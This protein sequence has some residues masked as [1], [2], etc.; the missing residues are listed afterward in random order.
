MG[1]KIYYKQNIDNVSTTQS[2]DTF[3]NIFTLNPLNSP[4]GSAGCYAGATPANGSQMGTYS[5]ATWSGYDEESSFSDMRDASVRP[6]S[7]DS[8]QNLRFMIRFQGDL[9]YSVGRQS[10]K[11]T[12]IRPERAELIAS[13]IETN[14]NR[15]SY[16][17]DSPYTRSEQPIAL[18]GSVNSPLLNA[19]LTSLKIN[20][21][22]F[23]PRFI[24][25]E[26]EYYNYNAQMGGYQNLSTGTAYTK[27]WSEIK[28]QDKTA[29]GAD[30]DSDLFDNG[31]KEIQAVNP[32]GRR[33]VH[34]I[35]VALQPYY[36]KSSYRLVNDAYVQSTNPDDGKVY[37]NREQ[38]GS[39]L[40][41]QNESPSIV[42][43]YYRAPYLYVMT[44]NYDNNSGGV[45]YSTP[46]GIYFTHHTTGGGV[47]YFNGYTIS[48]NYQKLGGGSSSWNPA[49]YA[50]NQNTNNVYKDS[51]SGEPTSTDLSIYSSISENDIVISPI[52]N[53]TDPYTGTIFYLQN[54]GQAYSFDLNSR[55]VSPITTHIYPIQ[56]LWATVA[57]LGCYVAADAE[58]ATKA[59][60]GAYTGENNSLYLGYMDGSGIT[61]GTMLQ[62]SDIVDS[63]QAGIDDIIG[64]TPYTP[65]E[66]G[67]GGGG[68]GS[69]PSN[70][71][72]P[73]GKG[74]GKLTGAGT[75]GHKTREFGSGSVTYYGL[76]VSQVED[77]KAALWSQPADFYDAIQIA[78]RQNTSI[79]DYIASFR[80]YPSNMNVMGISIGMA[81]PVYLGTGAKFSKAD[82]TD[83]LLN[84][85]TGFFG[86]IEWCRWNLSDFTGWRENFLDYAPYLKMSIYLPYAGTF[87][88]DPQVVASMNP[89]QQAT[90]YA[91][92]CVDLN[93]G[94]LTYFI[95]A[96]GV[97]VLEKTI[98]FGVDLPLT[99]ND[100]VQQSTAIIRSTNSL[101]STV[102]GGAAAVGTSIA[103]GN[104]VNAAGAAVNTATSLV[105][106]S[107]DAAL[108]NRQVPVQVGGFGGTMSNI[109]QGQ[110]PYITIYRQKIANPD[111]YG[112][113]VGY[114]T[115]SAH[116]ISELKGFTKCTNPDLSGISATDE[117]KAEI[118]SI[119][120]DGFYA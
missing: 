2:I 88:L 95:D 61:N 47:T 77:F 17:I 8:T 94:S 68:G 90:I 52:Y 49:I 38:F 110:D 22:V 66:P 55:S 37:G 6:V 10:F 89:I 35:G 18:N 86:Q 54:S 13:Q 117:E 34:C 91:R 75:T 67:P 45:Y 21:L 119:L 5:V 109:T 97:L 39:P 9:S 112:H 57:S 83:F 102:L 79:F 25:V 59:Q 46:T 64:N 43:T 51:G 15:A 80:Y 99:G 70:P 116:K 65:V 69:D 7:G 108:A 26:R 1:Y 78:G 3:D 111:N 20:E 115:Q 53:I 30:F 19:P 42:N 16:T 28:P 76:N 33:F 63:T 73:S 84:P 27:L 41:P 48:S 32:D 62:G 40:T 96:D 11:W 113:T 23:L 114:L 44:E 107:V 92:A 56:N 50:S 101:V 106:S 60:T 72:S 118:A 4:W 74:E 81:Q 12:G 36:G 93:T 24:F 98:K 120:T 103:S 82:G 104:V 71:P 87:D 14:L 58:T 85:M 31:W 100:S 29:A 105:N